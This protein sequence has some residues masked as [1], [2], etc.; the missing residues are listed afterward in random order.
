MKISECY[1]KIYHYTTW[2]GLCGIIETQSLWATNY[3]FLNDFSEV[4]LFKNKLVELLYPYTLEAYKDVMASHPDM[5]KRIH[6]AG[7]LAHV[8][9]NDTEAFVNAQYKATGDDIYILSFCGHHQDN[10]ININGLLSQWRGYGKDGGFVIVFNAAEIEQLLEEEFTIYQYNIGHISDVIY[11]DNEEYFE[12]ELSTSLGTIA[13]DLKKMFNPELFRKPKVILNLKSYSSFVSCITRYKH[14]GFKEENE[15]R[16]VALP[17]P[18]DQSY[19]NLAKEK[20]VDLKPEKIV[21]FRKNTGYD[22]P[23]IELFEAKNVKLPIERIIVG[24]HKDMEQR[25]ASLRVILRKFDIEIGCSD[26]PYIG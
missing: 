11:S 24:P 26:I 19:I 17:T 9:K 23:Y 8:V 5:E 14:Y 22:I 15:V 16:V 4:T 7:G 25:A 12:E 10:K 20:K 3:K 2:D 13:A 1:E 6:D 21:N 18:F